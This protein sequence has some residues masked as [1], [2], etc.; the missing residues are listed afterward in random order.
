M[1]KLIVLFMTCVLIGSVAMAKPLTEKQVQHLKSK[2]TLRGE[3]DKMILSIADMDILVNRDHIA[4][5]EIFQEDAK[6]I[7]KSI[8]QIRKI[9][10][11]GV[12][13]PFMRHLESLTRKFLYY[14]KKKDRR[15]M[16]YPEKIFNACFNCHTK[17]RTY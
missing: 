16:E 2:P 5:Y 3:M 12:F 17:H 11:Q 10:P 6:R 1:K 15:A 13:E 7:L 9:D 8:A 4:D 14:S